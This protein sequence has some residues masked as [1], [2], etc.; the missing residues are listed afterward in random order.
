MS[1]E[2]YQLPEAWWDATVFDAT[3]GADQ[4]LRGKERKRRKR[5]HRKKGGGKQTG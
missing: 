2:L 5:Q 3:R 4:G 1:N